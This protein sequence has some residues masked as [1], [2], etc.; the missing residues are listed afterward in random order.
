[1]KRT[2]WSLG[3]IKII[4]KVIETQNLKKTYITKKKEEGFLNGIKS[5]LKTEYIHIEALKGI[6]LDVFDGESLAF[7]G[8]NGA[9]KSTMIKI[10]TG[11]LYP[12]SGNVSVLG[13]TPWKD[14]A[15]LAYQIGVVFGQR[16]Q[17]WYHLPPID[18][19]NLFSKIYELERETYR[20]RLN[21]LIEIFEIKEYINV[22]VRKLSLGE[23]MRCEIAL[24]L[25]HSPKILFLDEPTIGLD[26]VAKSKM[27]DF[28][29]RISEKD[30]V[31]VFLSS[32]DT[33][34]IE[35]L[36]RRVVIINNGIIV[37]EGDINMLKRYVR[38]KI[39]NLK[40]KEAKRDFDIKGINVLETKD[41]GARLEIN[42]EE[43][44]QDEAVGEIIKKGQ[45]LDITIEDPPL[46]EIIKIIYEEK[47]KLET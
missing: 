43:I 47:G 31:T 5:L 11:I 29:R 14:R 1:M 7:I 23:R 33:I 2:T 18:S 28:I 27:R 16:S 12:T 25:L 37:Y 36:S 26:V 34:D 24:A 21:E 38:K 13:L 39:V 35:S 41:Y 45:I 30:H 20:T 46:E 42:L 6:S 8:P 19:F 4:E 15:K 10:L 44:S 40:F 9:G 17:L 32:H 3:G 22:P